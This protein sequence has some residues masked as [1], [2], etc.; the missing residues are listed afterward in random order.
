MKRLLV[1]LTLAGLSACS[2]GEAPKADDAS[3]AGF[4][5]TITHLFGSTVIKAKPQRVVAIGGGDMEAAISLAS[6]ATRWSTPGCRPTRGCTC[7]RRWLA[8]NKLYNAL[9]A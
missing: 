7:S 5:V 8:K 3:T 6:T 1:V 9:P 4:P 2:S